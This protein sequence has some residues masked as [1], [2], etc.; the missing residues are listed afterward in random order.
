M[1]IRQNKIIVIGSL[2]TDGS[3]PSRFNSC[4]NS[5]Y[6]PIELSSIYCNLA[7]LNDKIND[8]K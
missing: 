2:Y 8:E 1:S 5:R 4:E 3:E 7:L 6:K